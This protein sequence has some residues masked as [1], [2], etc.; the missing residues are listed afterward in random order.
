MAPPTSFFDLILMTYFNSPKCRCRAIWLIDE[1]SKFE[2]FRRT[3][4]RPTYCMHSFFTGLL[5]FWIM[6]NVPCSIWPK[7]GFINDFSQQVC[8]C[9]ASPMTPFLCFDTFV[10]FSPCKTP[11]M[12]MALWGFRPGPI[13][14]ASD[15][16]KFPYFLVPW[17]LLNALY[18]PHFFR[19]MQFCDDAAN[20]KAPCG[21]MTS[22]DKLCGGRC[23]HTLHSRWHSQLSS[24]LYCY[25]VILDILLNKAIT[26]S[27]AADARMHQV[28]WRGR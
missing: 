3:R 27:I 18:C 15:S 2:F 12:Q 23:Y 13:W 28:T 21:P 7:W 4:S 14:T 11:K 16:Q 24:E 17:R 10:L 5:C 26:H 22:C 19:V 9:Q 1:C 8:P 6:S 20:P 25:A